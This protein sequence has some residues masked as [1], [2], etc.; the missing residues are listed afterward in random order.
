MAV[1]SAAGLGSGLDISGLVSKLVAAEGDPAKARLT[2]QESSLTAEFSALG[3]LQSALSGLQASLEKVDK[4]SDFA[5]VKASS[6]NVDL[7][8]ATAEKGAAPG[9]FRVEVERLAQPHKLASA[10]LA[11]DA[12]F[13]GSDGD[14][15]T[16]MI[17]A[18]A[19]VIDLSQGNTLAELR[20]AVNSASDNPGVRATL[21]N[22]DET[23]QTLLL[24][25]TETGS[26]NRIEVTETISSGGSLALTTANRDADGNLLGDLT[27]L[28]AAVTIDGIPV[29]RPSNA[30]TDAIEGVSLSLRGAAPG[31][32]ADLAVAVDQQGISAAIS[33]FVDKYNGLVRT[34]SGV[35]GYRGEEADQPALFGDAMTRSIGNRL[36]SELGRSLPELDGAFASLADI[37]ITTKTDGTLVLDSAK[38]NEALSTDPAAVGQLFYSDQGYAPRFAAILSSYLDTGGVLDSRTAGV[39]SQI[40][41]IGDRRTALDERLTSLE[42]RYMRQFTALDAMVGQLSATS[43]FLTHQL[44]NLP[45]AWQPNKRN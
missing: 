14:S 13:G 24:T 45:G 10:S 16:L 43:D 22:V 17:N 8:T 11:A 12:T 36:R 44:A 26:A 29:T 42:E 23:H 20:D 6:G 15:L 2:K 38:L 30:I 41:D 28:D 37:G 7:F 32:P 31:S 1:L 35:S 3:T 5:L 18:E 25:A 34:L 21:I 19:L 33:S 9:N 4:A 27:G 40:D 39:Q